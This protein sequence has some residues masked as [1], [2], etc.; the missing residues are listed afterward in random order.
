[1]SLLKLLRSRA[2]GDALADRL[3]TQVRE[4]ARP[5]LDEIEALFPSFT[6]HTV[7]HSESVIAILDWLIPPE[8]RDALNEWEIY[9]LL[10]AAYLHDIGM[11]ENYPGSPAGPAWE[12][13]L[14]QYLS[15]HPGVSIDDE[16]TLQAVV[17][18]FVRDTHHHRS[19]EYIRHHGRALLGLNATGTGHEAAIVARISL[20]HRKTNLGDRDLFGET[21]FG[22]ENKP[23]RRDLL[24]AYLRIADELDT[25]A[26][27]TPVAE[28][29]SRTIPDQISKLEWGKHLSIQG[30]GS[31][32]G[33][34]VITGYCTDFDVYR[35]LN[36]LAIEIREKLIEAK[37]MLPKQ[38][39]HG[40]MLVINNPIPYYDVSLNIEHS[41]YL[42]I[43]LHFEM[44]DEQ[45][46]RLLLGERLYG[47]KRACVRELLQ[48]AVDTCQDA[49]LQRP[50]SWSPQISVT[51]SD[52]GRRIVFS[53]NG[54][55]MDEDIIRQYF[56]RVGLSYYRS[57]EFQ[58]RF[59]PIS[60]FGIGFLSC[61]MVAD[62]IEIETKRGEKPPIHL[63]VA[64]M[65]EPFVPTLG[66]RTE[67]GTDV[68]LHLRSGITELSDLTDI[69]RR[70]AKYASVPV[71]VKPMNGSEVSV[72]DNLSPPSVRELLNIAGLAN[73]VDLDQCAM[74]RVEREVHS[75]SFMHEHDGILIQGV[76]LDK[77]LTLRAQYPRFEAGSLRLYQDGFLVADFPR[78]Y[79]MFGQNSICEVNLTGAHRFELSPDRT[80]LGIGPS[81]VWRQIR[82]AYSDAVEGAI[83]QQID[84]LVSGKWWKY[85]LDHY[86]RDM[87]GVPQALA[88]EAEKNARYCV[89]L[90]DGFHVKT[91]EELRS[92]N[93]KVLMEASSRHKELEWLSALIPED[94]CMVFLPNSHLQDWTWR[95]IADEPSFGLVELLKRANA[96]I[97]SLDLGGILSIGFM[98][99]GYRLGVWKIHGDWV[100]FFEP[101]H[102]TVYDA[103][104]PLARVLLTWGP[105]AVRQNANSL[106]IIRELFQPMVVDTE[107]IHGAFDRVVSSLRE[108][109]II[110][111]N[112]DI[113]EMVDTPLT[114]HDC[115]YYE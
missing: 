50:A 7:R 16:D 81:D 17:R 48:N 72:T 105:E 74:S 86:S 55:G 93:G 24:A 40:G 57:H 97:K 102:V 22:V 58:A 53:D 36:R 39:V 23:I 45:I 87:K 90:P 63:E 80:R 77:L 49:K 1:M 107:D 112:T 27:R 21:V 68:T 82:E 4:L 67:S 13:Y 20:G 15:R 115:P 113:P 47:D 60:E 83:A 103:H 25:T 64:S 54:M 66:S 73:S 70:Y 42:P 41:G 71:R 92:W 95:L 110:G 69:V 98:D 19:E 30:V 94:K 76:L 38:Y 31:N 26:H 11:A 61:F 79:S 88:D 114:A 29:E 32:H 14:Q 111:R 109:G 91:V 108:D 44:H 78:E 101:S 56:S 3:E 10:A 100:Q 99:V 43:E 51:A 52:D 96:K 65:T 6:D 18:D 85:H 2:E 59:R 84:P 37:E 46:V 28:Y 104:H 33:T 75:A 5:K 62:R 34:L 9:F 35:R 89:L 12:N 8:V 106:R